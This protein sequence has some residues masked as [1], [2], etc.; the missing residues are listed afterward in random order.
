M[1]VPFLDFS[2]SYKELKTEIDLAISR[3]LESGYY[4]GGPEVESFE[5]EY[6]N[7][8]GTKYCVGVANGLDALILALKAC[9][10][11]HGD[12]VIVPSNTYIATW[13]AVS[14]VGAKIIPVEPDD[15]YNIDTNKIEEKITK[16]T[17]AIIPVHLYGQSVN[18][19]PILELSKKNSIKVI[20][21][22]AQ[23]HGAKY[24]DKRIGGHGDIIAWSFY[25]GKNLG[26]IGD[27]GAITT[28]DPEL[29]EKIKLYRN[30]GSRIKYYNEVQ[31]VNSRL[32]SIQAAIL[33]AKL[34]RLDQW[35][36]KRSAVATLYLNQ[37]SNVS[38]II[39]PKI[40]DWTTPVWHQFVIRTSHRD[41]LQKAL[42]EN[43]IGTMIH[44]PNPPHL[45]KAYEDL[46]W[47]QGSFPISEKIHTEV[48]SLPCNPDLTSDQI[49][50]VIDGIKK[51]LG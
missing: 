15:Y 38:Q 42:E 8:C 24:K 19:D 27:G 29:A 5:S 9:E 41:E 31:G 14:S 10:V 21:D 16:K 46:N 13:L 37:L 22:A 28:N 35:N 23:A 6:A 20:E 43:G 48:L 34:Q 32:D 26:A 17:K 18:L 7:Y 49:S 3:V 39:L 33:R 47:K 30:Y 36:E 4:I 45:Q 51:K 2:N 12:E 40:P 25:P 50:H 1:K 11:G 44:Y